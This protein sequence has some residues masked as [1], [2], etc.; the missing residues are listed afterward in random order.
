MI[1]ARVFGAMKPGAIFINGGR[2]ATV[3]EAALLAALDSGHA[4]RRRPRRVRDASRC[5]WIR[6]CAPIRA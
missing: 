4:A 1:D 2:G 5:R 6:R 3:Q